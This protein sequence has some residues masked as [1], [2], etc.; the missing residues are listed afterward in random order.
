MDTAHSD[1]FTKNL[2]DDIKDGLNVKNYQSAWTKFKN[3]WNDFW[4]GLKKKLHMDVSAGYAGGGG[5]GGGFAKG[6]IISGGQVYGFAKG[7]I[8]Y[9]KIKYCA[10]GAIINQPGRGVPITQ[11]IGGERGQEGILPLTDSQQMDLLGSAIARHLNLNATIPIYMG[12][13]Q[14]A[15]ELK[16]IQLNSDFAANR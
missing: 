16:K 4:S 10:S 14:I 11:A 2:P 9:P 15:R 5:G 7:G 13:K 12:N 8:T 6:G 3:G 1:T